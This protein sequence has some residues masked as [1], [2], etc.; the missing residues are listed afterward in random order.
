[1]G[2]QSKIIGIDPGKNGGIAVF[3]DGV[4]QAWAMP[5]TE[6]DVAELLW[7]FGR[8]KAFALLEKVHSMPKQGVKSTFTFG[9]GYGF[10]RGVLTA[11]RTPFDDVAPSTWQKSLSCLTKG[12]KNVTKQKAQQ[13]FPDL[14]ITHKVADAILICEYCRRTYGDC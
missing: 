7:D 13:L 2:E 8:G 9:R 4:M 5:D 10:L 11:Q 12:D 3:A 6:A 1:M 14:H